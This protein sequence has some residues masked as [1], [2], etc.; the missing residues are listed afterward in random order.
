[1]VHPTGLH[2]SASWV[3]QGGAVYAFLAG[4]GAELR[5]QSHFAVFN[6]LKTHLDATFFGSLVSIAMSGNMKA[7]PL[8][9]SQAHV[10]SGIC[11][12]LRHIYIIVV[13]TGKLIFCKVRNCAPPLNLAAL[14]DRTPRTCLRPALRI[15]LV[16]CFRVRN[17]RGVNIG[18]GDGGRGHVPPKILEKKFRAIFLK[19]N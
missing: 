5:P 9:Q 19:K 2:C 1:M 8:S 7:K 16:T 4:S 13:Q 14:F 15:I 17:I 10:E 18:V 12:Q 11:C 6:A 3:P